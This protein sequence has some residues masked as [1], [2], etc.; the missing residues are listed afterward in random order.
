MSAAAQ[1]LRGIGKG[2]PNEKRP[3]TEYFLCR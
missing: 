3:A 1:Q 2:S